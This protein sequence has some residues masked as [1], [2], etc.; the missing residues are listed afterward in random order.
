MRKVVYAPGLTIME[1]TLQLSFFEGQKVSSIESFRTNQPSLYS[2]ESIKPCIVQT[3]SQKDFKSILDSSP[4][5]KTEIEEHLYK[6]L[7]QSQRLFSLILK[8]IP[9]N[10]MKNW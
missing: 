6:R 7:L 1:K 5:F 2:I 4:E 10:A 3:I 8:I 9:S